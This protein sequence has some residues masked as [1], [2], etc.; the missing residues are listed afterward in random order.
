M[1][2][3]ESDEDLAERLVKTGL[4]KRESW[5]AIET[6]R[7]IADSCNVTLPKAERL[8]YPIREEDHEPWGTQRALR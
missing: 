8:R 7:Y 2:L 6:A 3:P 4:T 5:D 1:T